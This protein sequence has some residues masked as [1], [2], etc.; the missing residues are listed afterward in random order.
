MSKERKQVYLCTFGCQMN[1][2]DSERIAGLLDS[3]GYQLVDKEGSADIILFNT[4]SVRD[5]AEQRV[6]GRV[7]Q[8]GPLKKQKPELLIGILGC[9]AEKQKDELFNKLPM[10]DFVIGPRQ[11]FRIT[12]TLAGLLQSRQP[13][14]V[15]GVEEYC[16]LSK[17]QPKRGNRVKAWISIMEGCDNFC[18]Y[19]VVPYVRGRQVSRMESEIV[20]EVEQ[21]ARQGYKEITLLGQNVNSYQQNGIRFSDLIRRLN[22]INGIQRIR[23]MTSHPRDFTVEI[24]DAI[25]DS[26]KV[27]DHFHLPIQSA[28]DKILTLMNRGYTFAH[29]LSLVSEIRHRFPT[30]SITTD[31]IVGFPGET[32]A[33]YQLTLDAMKTIQWDS[34]FLFMFSPRSGTKAATLPDQVPFTIRKQRIHELIALQKKISEQKQKQFIGK[35]V[36]VL[37]EGISK[38]TRRTKSGHGQEPTQWFGRTRK[39]IV[40]VFPTHRDI[41]LGELVTITVTDAT[42]YTLFGNLT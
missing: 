24:I 9:M 26:P 12:E 20:D 23:Y 3:A 31:F 7:S 4:C 1:E 18:A 2:H 39:N 11:W 41:P 36:E 37:V 42:A 30:A 5:T 6:Y 38:H 28:S 17:H 15:T 22:R 34:A 32:D 21:L 13:K 35:Q 25:Q 14:V 10:V 33:D 19:C 16:N 8:L 27:C 40:A 29:Y